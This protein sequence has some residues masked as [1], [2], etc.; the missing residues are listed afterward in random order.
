MDIHKIIYEVLSL[1]KHSVRKT[2]RIK[3]VLNAHP[4]TTRGDPSQLQNALLNVALNACDA[5]PDGGV[6]TVTTESIGIADSNIPGLVYEIPPGDYLKIDIADTG[7][8]IP[9]EIADRIFDPF[10]TTK[11]NGK[12]TG[13]G[14]AAVYGTVKHHGGGIALHSEPDNGT[15]L[16]LFLP[17][18]A[19]VNHSG[20][21]VCEN[22]TTTV[23]N[24]HLLVVD[25]E[26]QVREMLASML[27][28]LNC[29]VTV[30]SNGRE[31]LEYFSSHRETVDAVI[32]DLIMPVMNG[33]TTFR[34]LKKL[35][36]E[37]KVIIASGYSIEG[38]ARQ[39][40]EEGADEFIQKPFLR[41][42]LAEKL[43][44]VLG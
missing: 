35:D 2:I 40:L 34:E 26:E 12:G 37:I 44:A 23:F 22:G 28:S 24:R 42:D 16:S 13:L 10:F 43:A 18:L 20:T 1:L 5:M 7:T 9:P 6:L 11:E 29:R 17:L 21:T 41:M 8:G 4:E 27:Q 25:D 19:E 38:D 33:A 32:L 30:C 31:A 15:A 3:Q 39:L 36:P 14:L